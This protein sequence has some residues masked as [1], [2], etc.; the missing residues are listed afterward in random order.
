MIEYNKA[1]LNR[2][3]WTK[4]IK[5]DLKKLEMEQSAFLDQIW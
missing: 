2:K 4:Q 5:L 3:D 1:E